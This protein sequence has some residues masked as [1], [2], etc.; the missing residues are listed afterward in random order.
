MLGDETDKEDQE[1]SQY[2]Y[3]GEA[4]EARLPR[5]GDCSHPRRR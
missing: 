2:T 1:K 4:L 3:Q 5:I